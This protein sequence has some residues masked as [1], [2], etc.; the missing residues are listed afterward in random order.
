VASWRAVPPLTTLRSPLLPTLFFGSRDIWSSYCFSFPKK[1]PCPSSPSNPKSSSFPFRM[2]AFEHS[3]I[4]L[5]DHSAVLA[6][7][8]RDP[9]PPLPPLSVMLN[10]LGSPPLSFLFTSCLHITSP[11]YD[12]FVKSFSC[13]SFLSHSGD[14]FGPEKMGWRIVLASESFSDYPAR[15]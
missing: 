11:Y 12:C 5:P 6:F 2:G 10:I 8:T 14:P 7:F 3:C 15:W 9:F 1:P 4:F 13:N